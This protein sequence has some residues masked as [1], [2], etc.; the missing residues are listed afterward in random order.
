MQFVGLPSVKMQKSVNDCEKLNVDNYNC[1]KLDS[2]YKYT[3]Q[4]EWWKCFVRFVNTV[5]S[6][7]ENAFFTVSAVS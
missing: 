4:T 5:F 3:A 2:G 6:S 1:K 7:V